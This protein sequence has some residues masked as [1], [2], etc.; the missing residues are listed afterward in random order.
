[1]IMRVAASEP[2]LTVFIKDVWQDKPLSN[3]T[4]LIDSVYFKSDTLGAVSIPQNFV[5]DKEIKIQKE[6][7]FPVVLR[8]KDIRNRQV[9]YLQS[10]ERS[11]EINIRSNR[12]KSAQRDLPGSYQQLKLREPF[13]K[14]S[15]GVSRLLESVSGVFIKDYGGNGGMKTVSVR[16]S[17]AEQT[18]ITYDGVQL[19]NPQLGMNDLSLIPLTAVKSLEIYRGGNSILF[20]SGAVGGTINFITQD[21]DSEQQI[22]AGIMAGDGEFQRYETDINFPIGILNQTVGF[23]YFDSQN[24]FPYEY[25]GIKRSRTNNDA[26]GFD[27]YYRGREKYT[28]IFGEVFYSSLERGMPQSLLISEGRARQ[29][30]QQI[31]SRIRWRRQDNFVIQFYH[32]EQFM[33]YNNP[34]IVINRVMLSSSHKNYISGVSMHTVFRLSDRQVLQT[35]VDAEHTSINSTDAGKHNRQRISGAAILNWRLLYWNKTN[36]ML[37]PAYRIDNY[38]DTGFTTMPKIGVSIQNEW[39]TLYSSIGKNFR[40]PTFNELYWQPG[41]NPALNPELSLNWEGGIR[42]VFNGLGRWNTSVVIYQ[43]RINNMI[44]WMPTEIANVSRPVNITSVRCK[45]MEAGLTYRPN[46]KFIFDIN[47]SFN[48]TRKMSSDSP[49]D[50]TVGKYLPYL[51]QELF[52]ITAS[53]EM[54]KWVFH[55]NVHRTSFRYTTYENAANAILSSYWYT[56]GGVS[57]NGKIWKKDYSAFV[58]IRNLT[59]T[60]YQLVEGYPMPGRGFYLGL[61]FTINKSGRD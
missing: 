22:R 41:G 55:F 12:L 48:D 53:W 17:N 24:N 40:A 14:E 43:N 1:M 10:V 3:V 44:R 37:Y 2:G 27:F 34:D 42:S 9:I 18:L 45:G 20:G 61:T 50:A 60:S 21:P 49:N 58:M 38:S 8:L 26:S 25:Q 54:E 36:L 19:T 4:L 35:K 52:N 29:K 5:S 6:N 30:S 16:G 15:E 47:Y 33:K 28:G 39:F 31:F 57:Y 7:Y 13:Q 23:S 56:A 59:N 46:K 51:P 11:A 32:H